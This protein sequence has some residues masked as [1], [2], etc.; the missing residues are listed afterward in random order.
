MNAFIKNVKVSYD[1]KSFLVEFEKSLKELEQM[2][3]NKS[4]QGKSSWRE[5]F[6]RKVN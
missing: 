2:R 3:N 5:L 4:S 1:E 6:E